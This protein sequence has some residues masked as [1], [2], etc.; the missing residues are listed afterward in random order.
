M[1]FPL[2][3]WTLSYQFD[4]GNLLAPSNLFERD[5][6][7]AFDSTPILVN[8]GVPVPGITLQPQT[9]DVWSSEVRFSSDLDGRFN[10]VTGVYILREEFVFDVEV[11]TINP[12]GGPVGRLQPGNSGTPDT[13][14]TFGMGNSFFGVHDTADLE[15]EAFFGEVYFDLTD[16][17]ELTA[18]LRYFPVGFTR[19]CHGGTFV[20]LCAGPC[21]RQ[22]R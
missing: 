8:F 22:H 12:D 13:D 20:R 9:R 5:L 10:F 19:D 17:W 4:F 18:G 3:A 11:L 15:Q 7:F 1:S 6:F 16:R 2:P 21:W 14:A